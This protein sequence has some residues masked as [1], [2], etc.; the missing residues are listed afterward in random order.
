MKKLKKKKRF[1]IIIVCA[2]LII[3]I[4]GMSAYGITP[5]NPT[6]DISANKDNLNMEHGEIKT[7]DYTITPKE[8][9]PRNKVEKEIILIIDTSQTMVVNDPYHNVLSAS[10]KFINTLLSSKDDSCKVGV[11]SYNGEAEIVSELSADSDTINQKVNNIGGSNWKVNNDHLGTNAGDALRLAISLFE[12]QN[13]NGKKVEKTVIFMTN[14]KPNAYTGKF[15]PDTNKSNLSGNSGKIYNMIN[16][17]G[18][19]NYNVDTNEFNNYQKYF[20]KNID[21]KIFA[22]RWFH[23]KSL[24][25]LINLINEYGYNYDYYDSARQAL[26]EVNTNNSFNGDHFNVKAME[27]KISYYL[28]F[29]VGY[30]YAL[31][32]ANQLKNNGITSYSIYF[33]KSSDKTRYNTVADMSEV[34]GNKKGDNIIQY[35]K[36][37][38]GDNLDA[39]FDEL[40]KDLDISYTVNDAKLNISVPTG[41]TIDS[42]VYNG[43]TIKVDKNDIKDGKYSFDLGNIKYKLNS[44]GNYV[45]NSFNISVNYQGENLTEKDLGGDIN[46][47]ITSQSVGSN[48][49]GDLPGIKATI[50]PG[51]NVKI[52]V[53][54]YIGE[55]GTPYEV[56][57]TAVRASDGSYNYFY[58]EPQRTPKTLI[59][60]G[61]ANISVKGA[62]DTKNQTYWIK[63]WF[64]KDNSEQEISPEEFKL[65]NMNSDIMLDKPNNLTYQ[66][67]NVGHLGTMDNEDSWN[68]R[69]QV[70]KSKQGNPGYLPTN[71]IA[72]YPQEYGTPENLN[73][74]RPIYVYGD[75]ECELT[76]TKKYKNEFIES[77]NRYENSEVWTY[78]W[79]NRV[80]EVYKYGN[81]WDNLKGGFIK[82]VSNWMWKPKTI[83]YDSMRVDD[84]N[85]RND[86]P[87]FTYKESDKYWG[88]L[89]PKESGWYLFGTES[90]DGSR[91]SLTVNNSTYELANSNFGVSGN[92]RWYIS[93]DRSNFK[94]HAA[95]FY[96]S[97]QPVYLEANK[98]YPIQ[99]E[100]FNWGGGGAFKLG[101]CK[102][103]NYNENIRD[104]FKML[105]KATTSQDYKDLDE[106]FYSKKL[107]YWPNNYY[108]YYIADN[109][110]NEYLNKLN[111]MGNGNNEV[112]TMYPSK[113]NEPGDVANEVFEGKSGVKLPVDNGVYTM[114]YKIFTRANGGKKGSSI[115]RDNIA[116]GS[117]GKFEIKD[118]LNAKIDVTDT[119]GGNKIYANSKAIVNYRMNPNPLKVTDVIRDGS[120]PPEQI[121]LSELKIVGLIPKG[122]KF[123]N[124]DISVNGRLESDGSTRIETNEM[125]DIIYTRQGDSYVANSMDKKINVLVESVGNFDFRE[126]QNRVGFKLIYNT[127]ET[128]PMLED[129]KGSSISI[130]EPTK[131]EKFG[132]LDS[133]SPDNIKDASGGIDVV[134]GMPLKIAILADIKSP[135]SVI[136]FGFNAN[137]IKNIGSGLK[138]K[139]YDKGSLYNSIEEFT[140]DELNKNLISGVNT[141]IRLKNLSLGEK[142]IVIEVT[143]DKISQGG[144]TLLKATVENGDEKIYS[145]RLQYEEMPDVF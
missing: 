17:M 141:G 9:N 82:E 92:N 23:R 104:A 43:K 56:G 73:S 8:F 42:I 85:Y 132:I 60:K 144:S 121:K 112:F 27:N 74:T 94:V 55:V 20:Y 19:D 40:Q 115:L 98:Y 59:G 16:T 133:G 89:K 72:Q 96:S 70:F 25:E 130:N 35:K 137:N 44:N 101:Y 106:V 51:V 61:F 21:D 26:D 102:L 123:I 86:Y 83:F 32:M 14:G 116:K 64:T 11:V 5:A 58:N 117:Y 97:F 126:D 12:N 75:T 136:D 30:E 76:N 91:F 46:G 119:S 142:V 120:N 22:P 52:S 18:E 127:K 138:V 48:S 110:I 134:N 33:G 6:F 118:L 80:Y 108:R 13:N 107:G 54:D 84:I 79:G 65:N 1:G 53:S 77:L 87:G 2:V 37:S 128:K 103:D 15:Y 105:N 111:W 99:L 122:L 3:S 57:K 100:Y 29:K 28:N 47:N 50:K 124:N 78:K 140:I 67:Y 139:V 143:P 95:A 145:A 45:S 129:F 36:T 81:Y 125:N 31:Y 71:K 38:Y 88:Y 131:I 93:Q 62:Q 49:L 109:N 63:T 10:N 34:A 4:I 113:S 135:T 7:V 41:A 69:G 39:I 90:D 24:D 114:H 66:A 68:D